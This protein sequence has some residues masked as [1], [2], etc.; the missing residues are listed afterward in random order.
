MMPAQYVIFVG[1]ADWYLGIAG[2]QDSAPSLIDSPDDAT[3]KQRAEALSQV[4]LTQDYIGQSVVLAIPSDWCLSATI[5]VNDLPRR[6]RGSAMTY[7]LEERLPIATEQFV[8][9]FILA[10][11]G[12]GDRQGKNPGDD[13]DGDSVGSP[14][15]RGGEALG[16]CVMLD[17]VGP[18]IQALES[19]GLLIH[20]IVPAA[21]LA[22]Q[23]NRETE[24]S[25][26]ADVL[27][28]LDGDGWCDVFMFDAEHAQPRS[29]L[30]LPGD[31]DTLSLHLNMMSI[32]GLAC[33]N[34]TVLGDD[35][36]SIQQV[37]A[38]LSS[39]HTVNVSTLNLLNE[40]AQGAASVLSDRSRP[41]VNLRRGELGASGS[42][43]L[44]KKPMAAALCAA[45]LLL[46][47]LNS[48]MLWRTH[49]YQ[50]TADKYDA[51][52]RHVFQEV[53]PGQNVPQAIRPRL[54]S[55]QLKLSGLRGQS[56]N[57]PTRP[58][59]LLLLHDILNRLPKDT[60]F[61]ILELSVR[62]DT[63]TLN[64][65]ARSHGDIGDL[66]NALR[67]GD[68][69]EVDTRHTEQLRSGNSVGFMIVVSPKLNPQRLTKR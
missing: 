52:Q 61:R 22:A 48:V 42:L 46:V 36:A 10:D 23:H 32:H 45:I 15:R 62:N 41:W 68:V 29:W 21:M 56:T 5:K 53:F 31:T 16:V 47:C 26:R 8:A 44:I 67:V 11:S 54:A 55:E 14:G 9:D 59:T 37:L 2:E 24:Q 25:S 65:E 35:S 63:V 50:Q 6:N 51:R 7:R 66:A 27:L 17:K 58:R 1:D 40:A 34:V 57:L 4:L 30:R 69:L 64:G 19:H 43:R 39:V 60:R 20:S 33:A 28:W 12:Q 49:G 3:V 18:V 13:S 38:E